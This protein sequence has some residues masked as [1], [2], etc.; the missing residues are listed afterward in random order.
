MCSEADLC[1]VGCGCGVSFPCCGAY[2]EGRATH[3]VTSVPAEDGVAV[4]GEQAEAHERL[5]RAGGAT[6]VGS[7]VRGA[8]V[9]FLRL[10][11]RLAHGPRL[12][13]LA[14]WP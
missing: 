11:R 10:L 13:P 7:G 3:R 5:C 1:V 14:V 2:H 4:V 12:A 8:V 9:V 6:A